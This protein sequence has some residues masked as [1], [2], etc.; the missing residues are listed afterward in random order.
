MPG[1]SLLIHIDN[2]QLYT[3]GSTVRGCAELVVEDKLDLECLEVELLGLAKSR[4]HTYVNGSYTAGEEKHRLLQI[5]TMVFPPP[6]VQDVTTSKNYTLT[7]G[8]YKYPFEFVFPGKE[9][10]AKCVTDKKT[11][12]SKYYLKKDKRDHATLVGSFYQEESSEDYFVIQY[13]IKGRVKTPS[14]FKFNIKQSVPIYFAP[15]NSEIFFSLLH[16]CDRSKNLLSDENHACQRVKYGIDSEV[17]ESKSFL[18]KLL[19]SNSVR[20]PF[21]LNVRFKETSPIETEKGIT[22]RVLEAGN[23]LSK[24]VDLDLSTSFS[25]SNLMDALGMNRSDKK[26][27][28]HPPAIKLTHIKVKLISKVRFLGA[29]ETYSTLK[30]DLLNQPLDLQI[31]LSDF[32]KVD[33]NGPHLV[34][35]SPSKY[36]DKLDKRVCYRLSLDP[37]WWDC[38]VND[39]GQSFLTCNIRKNVELYIRLTIACADN[40]EKEIKIKNTA[41]IVFHRQEGSNEP[42]YHEEEQLPPYMPAPAVHDDDSKS[43]DTK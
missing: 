15:R 34:N 20:V 4:N 8:R 5:T 9:H 35:Y 14:L 26:G 21:E 17:K 31:N 42:S 43:S 24:H 7:S 41:P 38:Y 32:E 25:Y 2:P 37:S 3:T 40:P 28:A 11:F 30:F 36:A 23:R 12:H 16:L 19:S 10:V 33:Y 39:I 29:T 27:I 18:K 13:S 6:D 1:N 22:N